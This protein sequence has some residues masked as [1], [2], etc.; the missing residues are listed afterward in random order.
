MT[1]EHFEWA[2]ALAF[3]LLAALIV[4]YGWLKV[5]DFTLWLTRSVKPKRLPTTP[6][7]IKL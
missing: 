3:V 7:G 5:I 6:P 1:Q 4:T 2:M